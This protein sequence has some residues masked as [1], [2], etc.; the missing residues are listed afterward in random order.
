M[1]RKLIFSFSVLLIMASTKAWAQT[2][3]NQ[4][5][6]FSQVKIDDPFWSPKLALWS[7][8]TVNDVFDKFEENYQTEGNLSKV[9]QSMGRSRNAFLNFDLVAQGKRG[10]NQHAG[11]PWYDG[12]VYE[13]IRRAADFLTMN[14]DKKLEQRI[15][16]Y[17]DR[18]ASAQASGT[19]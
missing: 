7:K 10:I 15:D 1:K 8:T 3:E 14:H 4:L 12:L 2:T 9:K 6:G 17:I 19:A 5:L 16:G 13:T 11:P 18:I